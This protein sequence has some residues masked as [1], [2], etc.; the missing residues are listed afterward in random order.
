M[1]RKT[2][3]LIFINALVMLAPPRL[4]A[5]P[6]RHVVLVSRLADV[7]SANSKTGKVKTELRE[8][9]VEMTGP[10]GKPE[11][12]RLFL[13][14]EPQSGAFSWTISLKDPAAD[15]SELTKWFK[16]DRA[17][18]LRDDR[19]VTFTAYRETLEIQDFQGHASSVDEAEQK[20]L[21]SAAAL[22]DPPGSMESAQPFHKVTLDG[23]ST[24][25]DCEP[26]FAVCGPSPKVIDV[27]WDRVEQHWI[28]TLKARW[29]EEFTL[30]ADYNVVSMRKVE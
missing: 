20:A 12:Y 7:G 3:V 16:R 18:F 26:G 15:L 22:N 30:D 4:A 8:V 29:T 5:G 19:L 11:P 14:F 23:L 25:F 21:S 6:D 27:Q 10:Y 1:F 28:V 24:D 13:I 2:A 17:A 9:Q